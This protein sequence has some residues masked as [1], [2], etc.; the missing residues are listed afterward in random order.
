[1]G[2]NIYNIQY[3]VYQKIY[4]LLQYIPIYQLWKKDQNIYQAELQDDIYN[5]PTFYPPAAGPRGEQEKSK[6]NSTDVWYIQP[7]HVGIFVYTIYQ[8]LSL[9]LARQSPFKGKRFEN[10]LPRLKPRLVYI[11][12]AYIPNCIYQWYIFIPYKH[13]WQEAFPETSWPG[14]VPRLADR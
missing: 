13:T 14:S 2:Q 3:K 4:A 6:E 12:R 9:R 1:M 8:L 10:G 5:I 7:E 11:A